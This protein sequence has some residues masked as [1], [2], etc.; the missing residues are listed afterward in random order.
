MIVTIRKEIYIHEIIEFFF[1]ND[2]MVKSFSFEI[3]LTALFLRGISG[4]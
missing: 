2:N 4:L 3:S 1:S